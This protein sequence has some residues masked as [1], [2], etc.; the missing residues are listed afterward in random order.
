[1]FE[2]ICPTSWSHGIH[3]S[4]QFVVLKLAHEGRFA[5][6]KV[7]SSQSSGSEAVGLK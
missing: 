4:S 1:M 5:I 2:N 3:V 7:S 6:E